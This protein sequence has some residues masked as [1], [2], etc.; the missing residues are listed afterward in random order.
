MKTSLPLSALL[1]FA[2]L[3]G[4]AE[5]KI[6]FQKHIKPLFEGNCNKCHNPDKAKGDVD[7]TTLSAILAGGGSGAI[8]TPGDAKNSGLYLTMAHLK[9]PFMPQKASKLS[10]P[11]L[12]LVRKWIDGGMLDTEGSLA[13]KPKK[14]SVDLSLASV[15]LDKPDGPP[16]MPE[17]LILQPVV[18]TS[19]ANAVTAL[20]H[21]P[22]APV[23]AVGGQKQVLLYHTDTQELLGVL[24]FPEGNVFSVRFSR[25]GKL[26][27]A[28]GGIEGKSGKAV[29]YEVL[30]GRRLYE[31][32]D[33]YDSILAADLSAD[34]QFIATGSTDRF[35]K[36]YSIR[37]GRRVFKIK[38]HTDW[39]TTVAFSPDGVLLATGDRNGGLQVWETSTGQEFY[40][41][42][43]H[44]SMINSVSWRR[45]SNLLASSSEDGTIRLWN[46]ADGNEA[47][48]WEAHGKRVLCVDFAPD[49]NLFS[50]GKDNIARLF[51]PDGGEVAKYEGFDDLTVAVASSQDGQKVLV[52][53][54]TGKISVFHAAEK[55]MLG[56]F[57]PAP[58]ALDTRLAAARAEFEKRKGERD[59]AQA[60]LNE[61]KAAEADLAARQQKAEEVH[62]AK[63]KAVADGKVK[64]AEFEQ[65]VAS[66]GSVRGEAEKAFKELTAQVDARKGE[67]AAWEKGLADKTAALKA[68]QAVTNATPEQVKAQV[69]PLQNEINGLNGQLDAGRKDLA[70]KEEQRQK[71]GDALAARDKAAA[72]AKAAADGLRPQIDVWR[73]ERAAAE[74]DKL[75]LAAELETRRKEVPD[76][77]KQAQEAQA[78]FA[79]AEAQVKKWELAKFNLDVQAARLAV[80]EKDAMVR[81]QEDQVTQQ[82]AALQ[83]ASS[84][85][86][87]AE[88]QFKKL[89]EEYKSRKGG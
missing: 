28:A 89:Q 20:A 23:F 87:Q 22:W 64:L 47:K 6:T 79:Q 49:G 84:A 69:D 37:D 61:K 14:P 78:Q 11:E 63:I 27:L 76:V 19:R 21:S 15:S 77:E 68:A 33:D 66:A 71:Q 74:K 24:P 58:P 55:K 59:A 8:A 17:D 88:E 60:K 51:K 45:D 31:V 9:E 36:I 48:K 57:D 54:W 44:A 40:S 50:C 85:K 26:L 1:A 30:T 81:A 34:Q 46:M 18:L 7:L 25:N 41:L 62:A 16:P 83:Q 42:R 4:F 32:G 5:E 39:V 75:A 70:A 73:G 3:P 43:G 72:E 13:L 35:V 82:Q 2:F 67:I 10:D 53:D 38:K 65:A 29:L 52:G 12:E 56:R 86:Q 80:E